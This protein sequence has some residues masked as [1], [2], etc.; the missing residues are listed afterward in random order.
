MDILTFLSKQKYLLY[1]KGFQKILVH[2]IIIQQPKFMYQL[3]VLK[4]IK[5]LK[6]G[7]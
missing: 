7:D 2:Y 3:P 5:S 6:I 4:L 1:L